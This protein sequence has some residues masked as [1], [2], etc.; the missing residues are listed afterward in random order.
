MQPI[1]K[2]CSIHVLQKFGNFFQKILRTSSQYLLAKF[3]FDTAENESSKV[4]FLDFL[5]PKVLMYKHGM[6]RSLLAGLA[7]VKKQRGATHS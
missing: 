7:R 5:I 4:I 1:F 6:F 2:K 3:G